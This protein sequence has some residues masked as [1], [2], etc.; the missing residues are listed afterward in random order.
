M[1]N[2]VYIGGGGA[3]MLVAATQS[4]R[5]NV[6]NLMIYLYPFFPFCALATLRCV[7]GAGAAHDSHLF[8]V[9]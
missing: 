6:R 2:V 5:S 3:Y 4:E 9:L 1:Q 8:N 7:A